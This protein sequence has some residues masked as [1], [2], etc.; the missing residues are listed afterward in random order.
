M[1][2]ITLSI[3]APCIK[4]LTSVPKRASLSMV[5]T[6]KVNH[7]T[8]DRQKLKKTQP[9]SACFGTLPLLLVAPFPDT[10][11]LPPPE[12]YRDVARLKNEVEKCIHCS[13]LYNCTQ[14][15]LDRGGKSV[16]NA[17]PARDIKTIG[18]LSEE[19]SE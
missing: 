10:A 12:D 4:A 15:S 18:K 3:R 17:S 6:L 19:E 7:S 5:L 9:P 1:H 14:E 8:I 16:V 11:N 13:K 2:S